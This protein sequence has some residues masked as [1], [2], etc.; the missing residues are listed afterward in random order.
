[1]KSM[2]KMRKLHRTCLVCRNKL[3]IT[4]YPDGHYRN[5][6]YFN[7]FKIPVKGTGEYKKIGMSKL[8]G[9]KLNVVKWTGKE[10]EIEYWE[11]NTC[12]EEAKGENWLEKKI[13]DLYGKR[14]PDY[15]RG[16]ACCQAWNI[17]D[18][19]VQENRGQL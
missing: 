7:K 2:T 12:Y 18:N 1:M 17:Y 6:H 4:L 14:C 19:I 16:C 5:G 8:L 11:C 10:K 13:E 9:K 3:Q 15:E